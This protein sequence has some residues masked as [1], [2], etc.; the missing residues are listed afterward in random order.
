MLEEASPFVTAQAVCKVPNIQMKPIGR[1][2][3]LIRASRT[4]VTF[5][6][7]PTDSRRSGLGTRQLR[8]AAKPVSSCP[9]SAAAAA[10]AA[11]LGGTRG[12]DTAVLST[13]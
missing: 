4:E 8:G 1:F 10:A 7:M 6:F 2:C 11:R 12:R 5:P 3:T 13:Q 9:S